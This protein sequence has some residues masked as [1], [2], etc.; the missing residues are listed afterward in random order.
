MERQQYDDAVK[1]FKAYAET[2]AAA[3]NFGVPMLSL[4]RFLGLMG[5]AGGG[6]QI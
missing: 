4:N 5:L 1:R 3:D 2:K 6:G